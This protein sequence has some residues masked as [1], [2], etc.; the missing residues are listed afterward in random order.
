[1]DNIFECKVRRSSS[2]TFVVATLVIGILC[3]IL[4]FTLNGDRYEDIRNQFLWGFLVFICISILGKRFSEIKMTVHIGQGEIV[5]LEVHDSGNRHLLLTGPFQTVA[6]FQKIQIKRN[7][8]APVLY[9][10][11]KG[12]NNTQLLLKFDGGALV[13]V[14]AGW[15]ELN[16]DFDSD[17]PVYTCREIVAVESAISGS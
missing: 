17:V 16:E 6:G 5:Q 9:L 2:S 14:P 15:G 11:I 10:F 3:L 8:S 13:K 4:F 12:S 1:M 7:I